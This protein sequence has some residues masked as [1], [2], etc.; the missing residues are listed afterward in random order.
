[1]LIACFKI[2]ASKSN[3]FWLCCAVVHSDVNCFSES[4]D[5]PI[6]VFGYRTH[7]HALGKVITGYLYNATVS[8]ISMANGNAIILR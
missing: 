4:T 5:A 2:K 6:Y 3:Q 1:M 8:F 7:A